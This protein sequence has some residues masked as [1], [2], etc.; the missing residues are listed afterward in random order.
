[1]LYFYLSA[2][3]YNFYFWK[4]EDKIN[5]DIPN[6]ELQSET[7][8]NLELWQMLSFCI[9]WYYAVMTLI[10]EPNSWKFLHQIAVI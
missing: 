2:R 5:W 6:V 8:E 7:L 1:M 10:S 9:F 4:Y 3:I